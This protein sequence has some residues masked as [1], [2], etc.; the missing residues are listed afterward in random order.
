MRLSEVVLGVYLLVKVV[1]KYL[2][3]YFFFKFRR[4]GFFEFYGEV[5]DIFFC[6]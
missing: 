5:R 6:I 4:D 2:V 1:V 3:V